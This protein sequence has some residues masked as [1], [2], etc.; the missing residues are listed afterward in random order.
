MYPKT[1]RVQVPLMAFVAIIDLSK[2]LK[3]DPSEDYTIVLWDWRGFISSRKNPAG[4][5]KK[6]RRALIEAVEAKCPSYTQAELGRL[7]LIGLVGKE[8][9][10]WVVAHEDFK[11]VLTMSPVGI[12]K[13]NPDYAGP[14]QDEDDS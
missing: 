3:F 7:L 13:E 2:I 4:F 1:L 14:D 10:W 9:S 5:N 12:I 6:H 8:N 11:S